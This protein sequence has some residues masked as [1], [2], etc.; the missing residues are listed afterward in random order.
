[1]LWTL[2]P[3]RLLPSAYQA[4]SLACHHWLLSVFPGCA[5][6]LPLGSEPSLS[7]AG[8]CCSSVPEQVCVLCAT[9]AMASLV[10]YQ[11]PCSLPAFMPCPRAL[12]NVAHAGVRAALLETPRQPCLSAGHV[13]SGTQPCLCAGQVL[14]VTT[15]CLCAGQVLSVTPVDS[16]NVGCG[17]LLVQ[18][19]ISQQ[20]AY[21]Y[22]GTQVGKAPLWEPL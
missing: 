7:L 9:K 15:P 6:F 5:P 13:L 1:M 18:A 3:L 21:L 10:S 11:A 22:N 20:N 4:V 16:T 17:G 8:T 12:S 14:C 2:R 19:E